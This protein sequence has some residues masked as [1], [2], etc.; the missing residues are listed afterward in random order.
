[1]VEIKLLQKKSENL[2]PSKIKLDIQYEDKDILVVNKPKG[3]V[4]HPGAGNLKTLWL[5][6][7]FINIKINYQILMENLDQV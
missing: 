2:K 7:C 6:L 3:M 1:M 5:M 4:V